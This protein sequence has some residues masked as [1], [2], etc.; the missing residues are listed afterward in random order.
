LTL[1]FHFLALTSDKVDSPL[2]LTPPTP[3]HAT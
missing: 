1:A 2:T 3:I